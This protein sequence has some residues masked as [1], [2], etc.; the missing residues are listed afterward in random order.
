MLAS[1]FKTTSTSLVNLKQKTALK[2]SGISAPNWSAFEL[3]EAWSRWGMDHMPRCQLNHWT[4][5]TRGKEGP[6][7]FGEARREE[8]R[9]SWKFWLPGWRDV[10]FVRHFLQS[11]SMEVCLELFSCLFNQKAHGKICESL[12]VDSG[13][14]TCLL[15]WRKSWWQQPQQPSSVWF[16]AILAQKRFRNSKAAKVVL[17]HAIGHRS[18]YQHVG[19]QMG[20]PSIGRSEIGTGTLPSLSKCTSYRWRNQKSLDLAITRSLFLQSQWLFRSQFQWCWLWFLGITGWKC[21]WMEW[22]QIC[23]ASWKATDPRSRPPIP[24]IRECLWNSDP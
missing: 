11:V 17:H 18:S 7:Q 20:P 8:V 2:T 5:V 3:S 24:R 21:G 13:K 1:L 4:V 9:F 12:G 6:A 19:R 22:T 23:P 15:R 14:V 16:Q 10:G